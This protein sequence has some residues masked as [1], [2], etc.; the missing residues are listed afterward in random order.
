MLSLLKSKKGGKCIDNKN[1]SI[2]IGTI[3]YLLNI[4]AIN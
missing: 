3:S 2:I 1:D 4:D